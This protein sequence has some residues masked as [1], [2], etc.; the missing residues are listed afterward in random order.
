MQSSKTS[1]KRNR[2]LS[3]VKLPPDLND[4]MLP[5]Y[6]VYY[7]E[8]YNQE[9]MLFR[10]FFKVEKHPNI[11]NKKCMCSSK[12]NKITI[13]EKLDQIKHILK[14]INEENEENEEKGEKEN[15]EKGA[16]ESKICDDIN[17]KQ[18]LPKYVSIK[19]HED[20]NKFY[21]IYDKKNICGRQTLKLIYNKA[22]K[23]MDFSQS[24]LDF[25][26]KIEERFKDS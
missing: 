15:E 19:Q 2:K 4:S 18:L 20:K 5:K 7:K 17:T 6:V 9:K 21:F 14:N 1:E 22:N 3:A 10:E 23:N 16:N 8:C 12:S 26:K 11:K 13:M 25:T 24:L